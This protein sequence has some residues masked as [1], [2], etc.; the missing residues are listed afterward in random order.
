M[1]HTK[2]PDL[3]AHAIGC[4]RPGM[5]WQARLRQDLPRRGYCPDCGALAITG[6][7]TPEPTRTTN[8]KG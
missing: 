5:V 1:N 4:R 2:V 3:T 7:A 6:R 8:T